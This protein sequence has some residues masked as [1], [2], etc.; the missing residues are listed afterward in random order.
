LPCPRPYEL[1]RRNPF[2]EV[3]RKFRNFDLIVSGW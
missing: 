3:N 2:A 1:Q